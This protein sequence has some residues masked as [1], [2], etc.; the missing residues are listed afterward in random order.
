MQNGSEIAEIWA[1]ENFGR[2]AKTECQS[3]SNMISFETF[4]API[5]TVMKRT[6]LGTLFG[7][8]WS[9]LLL[10]NW[11]IC[12]ARQSALARADS[13]PGDK[14]KTTIFFGRDLTHYSTNFRLF[15][16]F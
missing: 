9:W 1:R 12:A 16:I 4:F 14:K 13:Q 5:L 11:E 15:L 2:T 8:L 6:C 7:W 10:Q 3:H